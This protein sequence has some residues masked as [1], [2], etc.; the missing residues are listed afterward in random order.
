[1]TKKLKLNVQP[2]STRLQKALNTRGKDL[3]YVGPSHYKQ[4]PVI[5]ST[6]GKLTEIH[7]IPYYKSTGIIMRCTGESTL[8]GYCTE[9]PKE[10]LEKAFQNYHITNFDDHHFFGSGDFEP[11]TPMIG[12]GIFALENP[13]AYGINYNG[14]LERLLQLPG[15][16]KAKRKEPISKKDIERIVAYLGKEDEHGFLNPNNNQ[17]KHDKKEVI[18]IL[19]KFKK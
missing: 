18:T 12:L 15:A 2:L 14:R 5:D 4:N 9:S 10:V 6:E 17:V 7:L 8:L 3:I 19:K 13:T 11:S 1:M 16:L